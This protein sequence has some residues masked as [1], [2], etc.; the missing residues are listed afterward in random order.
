MQLLGSIIYITSAFYS[1]EG[2]VYLVH[3]THSFFVTSSYN[4][5]SVFSRWDN[6]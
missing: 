4:R 1:F 5:N 3:W 2:V 6:P